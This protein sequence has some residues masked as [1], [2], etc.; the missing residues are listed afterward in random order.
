MSFVIILLSSFL[1]SLGVGGGALTSLYFTVF[2]DIE[3][4]L[5]TTAAIILFMP[6]AIISVAVGV[7][8]GYVKLKVASITAVGGVIGSLVGFWIW[9]VVETSVLRSIFAGFLIIFGI[10]ELFLKKM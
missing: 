6:T 3:I 2:L 7:K 9:S 10:R 4:K 1:T 5:A 8:N